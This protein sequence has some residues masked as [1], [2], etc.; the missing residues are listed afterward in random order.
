[1]LVHRAGGS[2][3]AA[4]GAGLLSLLA[5]QAAHAQV[6]LEYK[7]PEGKKATYKTTTKTQQNLTIQGME[8][9]TESQQTVVSSEAIG[10]RRDDSGLPMEHKIH[11]LRV[12]L[13]LPMGINVSYDSSD[14]DAKIDNDQ[15]AFLGDIFKMASQIAYTVVLDGQNK[16]KAIE[17]VEKLLEKVDKLDGQAR[18]AL[19][20]RLQAEKLKTQFEQ[21]HKNLP[22]V[23]ARKGEP[24]ERTETLE[25]EGGQT[26]TFKKK[27]EYEGTENKAGKTLHVITSKTVDVK[28]SMDPDAPT[29][30]KVTKSDLKIA[31]SRGK[32][33]F[34]AEEGRVIESDNKTHIKG[35]M[36]FSAQGQDLPGEL[37]LTLEHKTQLEP[38]TK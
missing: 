17:G 7:F 29:P 28:Y 33:L 32:I 1:M 27:Y 31:S 37:D 2:L 10:K 22:E 13:M 9:T 15:L 26:L 16:V 8:V 25:V 21:E 20:S 24:W 38:A 23:L 12:E 30:L 14:P 5:S 3:V 4:L 35:S 34:D 18:D 11:S 6:K 36:T 19:K